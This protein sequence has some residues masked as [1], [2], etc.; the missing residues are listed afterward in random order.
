MDWVGW[1]LKGTRRSLDIVGLGA[2]APVG[3]D[4]LPGPFSCVSH[5][6]PAWEQL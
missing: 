4:D 2:E 5:T 6:A 3:C 1:E